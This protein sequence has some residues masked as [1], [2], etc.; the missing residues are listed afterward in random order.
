[1]PYLWTGWLYGHEEAALLWP[2]ARR[3]ASD[4]SWYLRA[5]GATLHALQQTLTADGHIVFIGQNRELAYHETLALAAAGVDLRLESVLYHPCGPERATKPFSGLRGDYRLTWAQGPPVPP[6]PVTVGE[7]ADKVSQAVVAAAEQILEQRGE[8]SP[9][10]RLHCAIWEALAQ[11]GLLQRLMSAEEQA[12]SQ[13]DSVR[14]QI[15]AALEK[16]VG[17]TFV[18]LW[19]DEERDSKCLWWL[20]Q[21]PADHFPLS[22]R[23]EQVAY[24]TLKAVEVIGTERFMQIVYSHFT[25]GLTHDAEWV[26]A[27]LQS[28]GQQISP[29]RWSLREEDRP[30]QRRVARTMARQ[31]L[32]NLGR[33]LG[34]EVR[35]GH[36]G[37]DVQWVQ[38][39]KATL[40]FVVLDS[41]ALSRLVGVR[42][43][44][45]SDG[46]RR[47]A[48]I[49]E[50][51]QGLLR[52]RL[53]RSMHLRK[54]LASEGWRLIRSLDLQEWASQ[55]KI[56]LA[57]LDSLA[58]LE[59]LAAQDRTQLSL[60]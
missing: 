42:A 50:A 15:R 26:R 43:L 31:T 37:F 3:R 21:P 27:C 7:L 13:L 11:K 8:P 35:I 55:S 17:R 56:T 16:E 24:E 45:E 40:A 54:Q 10:V 28:Y 58:G 19:E 2:L 18:Q 51:R 14:E 33:R 49:P 25:R 1:M 53:A 4:W 57:D 6:W 32:D 41:A 29:L 52:L 12:P 47:F 34:Y 20:S 23:I 60:I 9:F 59:P 39:G 5:M 22:E 44:G 30:E 36:K 48:V 46:V 38:A